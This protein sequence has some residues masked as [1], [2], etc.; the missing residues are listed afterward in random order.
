MMRASPRRTQ[1]VGSGTA[2]AGVAR[3]EATGVRSRDFS[4]LAGR[5]YGAGDEL[6][7]EHDRIE[8]IA[9]AA[10]SRATRHAQRARLGDY[11]PPGLP[12]PFVPGAGAAAAQLTDV[13]R[14]MT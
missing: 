11:P 12:P 8:A 5:L 1:H 14:Q 9:A 3:A 6:A 13:L 7:A 2:E 10:R 4:R